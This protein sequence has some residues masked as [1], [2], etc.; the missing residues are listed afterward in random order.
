MERIVGD[1][2]DEDI[3]LAEMGEDADIDHL[4]DMA[5]EA[6]VIK[7]VNLLIAKAIDEGAS[8]IHVEPYEDRLKI[9]QEVKKVLNDLTLERNREIINLSQKIDMLANN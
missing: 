9:R 7:L 4:R 5:H 1:I 3:D 6:P 8:D 2:G